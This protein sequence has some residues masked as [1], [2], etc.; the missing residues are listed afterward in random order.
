M[1]GAESGEAIEHLRCRACDHNISVARIRGDVALVCHCTHVDGEI[2]SV[3][4][5]ETDS[6]PDRWKWIKEGAA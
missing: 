3:S 4:T 1:T 6:A 2:D 5:E